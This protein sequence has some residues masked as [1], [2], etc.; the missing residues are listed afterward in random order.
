MPGRGVFPRSP[1]LP[2]YF[3]LRNNRPRAAG[4]SIQES[5]RSGSKS[6]GLGRQTR[7]QSRD[8]AEHAADRHLSAELI[9]LA[10]RREPDLAGRPPRR[11]TCTRREARV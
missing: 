3:T 4:A 6:E 11:F 1:G 7:R 9:P 2:C 8:P 5:R 10:I